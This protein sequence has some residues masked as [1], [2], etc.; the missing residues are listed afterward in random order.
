MGGATPGRQ[1]ALPQGR[2]AAQSALFSRPTHSAEMRP[3][4]WRERAGVGPLEGPWRSARGGRKDGARS[5][6]WRTRAFYLHDVH[7]GERLRQQRVRVEHFGSGPLHATSLSSM[8]MRLLFKLL[9][10]WCEYSDEWPLAGVFVDS[11]PRT[12]S[13]RG[14]PATAQQLTSRANTRRL[15]TCPGGDSADR[16]R[17]APAGKKQREKEDEI[18]HVFVKHTLNEMHA[19][20]FRSVSWLVR[21]AIERR[22]GQE[23]CRVTN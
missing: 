18:R 19:R 16:E 3:G 23:T 12:G 4:G 7:D 9:S 11:G 22:A 17:K 1:V 14:W 21:Y 10:S 6:R 2:D 13:V 5:R 15:F 20:T 8:V